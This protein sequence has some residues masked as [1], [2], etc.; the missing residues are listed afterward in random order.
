[1]Q[2]R[3]KVCS[4]SLKSINPPGDYWERRVAASTNTTDIPSHAGT[5]ATTAT[6]TTTSVSVYR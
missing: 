3:N 4:D 6:S 1:M 2:S 5:A